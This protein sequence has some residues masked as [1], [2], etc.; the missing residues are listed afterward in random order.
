MLLWQVPPGSILIAHEHLF[1]RGTAADPAATFRPAF[2]MSASRVSEPERPSWNHEPGAAVATRPFA[3]TG[4]PPATQAIYES[5]W[6]WLCG[7]PQADSAESADVDVQAAVAMLRDSESEVDRTGAAYQ[8]ARSG[9]RGV[10][11]LLECA[12]GDVQDPREGPRRAAFY[13]LRAVPAAHQGMVAAVLLPV[14]AQPFVENSGSVGGTA[15]VLYVLGAAPAELCAELTRSLVSW[16]Q[17]TRDELASLRAQAEGA[18]EGMRVPQP[19]EDRRRALVEAMYTLSRAAA[20]ALAAGQSELVL[21]A[22]R[23]LEQAAFDGGADGAQ[24]TTDGGSSGNKSHAKS[25]AHSAAAALLRLC[26]DGMLAASMYAKAMSWPVGWQGNG[27]S[28]VTAAET[29]GEALRRLRLLVPSAAPSDTARIDLLSWLEK[30]AAG[31]GERWCGRGEWAYAEC[32]EVAQGAE[33]LHFAT[34]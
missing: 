34:A 31:R 16:V 22:A 10:E 12:V 21:L 6:S 2:K 9:R 18:A 7:R 26:S 17:R 3:D 33:H 20:H 13:G 15:A 32:A 19:V 25:V 23:T 24:A 1:H 28:V 14:L 8:L 5:V 29:V 11:V 30:A 4:A 27:A